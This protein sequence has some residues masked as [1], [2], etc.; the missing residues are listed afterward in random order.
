MTFASRLG[1]IIGLLG[2]A[3]L[4]GACSAIK[5]GY[6]NLDQVA[7][8]W[9]DSYV[10]FSDEQGS[11][12]REDL[13]RLHRWHRTQ[14]LPRFA[15]ILQGIEQLA[16][17]DIS[18]AQACEVF[19]QFRERLDALAAQAEPAVVT[20]AT[21]LA[22]EQVTH[23]A[24][25][26]EKNNADFRKEWILPAPPEQADKRLEQL[27]ERSEMVYGRLEEPQ[28]AVLRRH[29]QQSV[30]DPK[31]ALAERQRR[32]RDA[33]QTV[34]KI[35]GT[36][37]P[38]GEARTLLR[39]YLDRVREPPDPVQRAYQQALIEEGCNT[40]AALHNSTTQ[41][42]RESAVRRLRAYQRDLRELAAQ[43]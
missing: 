27:V 29:L 12:V 25:K 38:L 11:R 17:G 39:G 3:A 37:V 4:L 24:R 28:R 19:A 23:L 43:R 33:L 35:A 16:P 32:Q 36:P 8:W 41:A 18:G 6:N 14:E 22:P 2:L 13:A 20:L 15:V 5:L 21:D 31:R 26:Y 10:D 40:F 7:Y 42:Q 34:R 9:L 30:F 1:R